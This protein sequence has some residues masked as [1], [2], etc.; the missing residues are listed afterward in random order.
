MEI[1][2]VTVSYPLRDCWDQ[3]VTTDDG[4]AFARRGTPREPEI[5]WFE[6]KRGAPGLEGLEGEPKEFID[7]DELPEAWLFEACPD[8]PISLE[9]SGL[10][11]RLELEAM[12]GTT[13]I[14]IL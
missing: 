1:N 13:D 11:T 5:L 10:F 4:R 8:D 3:Y 14:Y 6:V 7:A 2:V 9:I 12:P